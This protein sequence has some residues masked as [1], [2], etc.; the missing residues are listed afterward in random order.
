[1]KTLWRR[2]E[3]SSI[4]IQ[5]GV[6]EAFNNWNLRKRML[7]IFTLAVVPFC[8]TMV[9]LLLFFRSSM[10][11]QVLESSDNTVYLMSVSTNQLMDNIEESTI[12]IIS[13][14]AITEF[15]QEEE[16]DAVTLYHFRKDLEENYM[17]PI[18]GAVRL[19]KSIEIESEKRGDCYSFGN[20]RSGDRALYKQDYGNGEDLD[21]KNQKWF[22][23]EDTYNG[24]NEISIVYR[25]EIF[26][27]STKQ[28]L[29][30]IYVEISEKDISNGLLYEFNYLENSEIQL[31]D[32]DGTVIVGDEKFFS[33]EK[34]SEIYK[35]SIVEEDEKRAVTKSIEGEKYILDYS[36]LPNGWWVVHIIPH[37]EIFSSIDKMFMIVMIIFGLVAVSIVFL[38]FIISRSVTRPIELLETTMEEVKKGDFSRSVPVV[39]GG[40]VGRLC[41]GFNIMIQKINSLFQEFEIKQR[42]KKEAELRS[43]QNQISPHFLYNILNSLACDARLKGDEDYAEVLN[44]LISLLRKS[45]NYKKEYITVEEEISLLE[46]YLHLQQFRYR[47]KFVYSISVAEEA[48]KY[49]SLKLILQPIAEN[50]ILHGMSSLLMSIQITVEKRDSEIWICI[51]DDGIGISEQRLLEVRNELLDESEDSERH[52][53][54]KNVNKRIKLYFGEQYG[55]NIDSSNQKTKIDIHFPAILEE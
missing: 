39:S 46:N 20:N 3:Y 52:I 53:G 47:N 36:K 42:E 50:C 12:Q 34:I 22:W 30:T 23:F 55:V 51:A 38:T 11:E 41:N 31:V 18:L 1:M 17:N 13:M 44:N 5:H 28:K 48:K 32:S 24:K 40:E 37:K 7:F 49:R 15:L 29:G 35:K 2:I 16:M 10:K 43:L 33:N 14:P 8:I 6:K 45:L 54:L 4:N 21:S 27:F 19:V 9:A 26:E 25:R